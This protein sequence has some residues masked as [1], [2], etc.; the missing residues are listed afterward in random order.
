MVTSQTGMPEA[1][2]IV[3]LAT[4]FR[5]TGTDDNSLEFP[6]FIYALKDQKIINKAYF[7]FYWNPSQAFI[8]WG[9][10][11][12]SD[13][14]TDKTTGKLFKMH[15]LQSLPGDFWWTNYISGYRFVDTKG[16]TVDY[17]VGSTNNKIFTDSGTNCSY[18][19]SKYYNQFGNL[20][21]AYAGSYT[22][23]STDGYKIDCDKQSIMPDVFFNIGG[24]WY[25]QQ[26]IHY[27]YNN[28]QMQTKTCQICVK[29]AGNSDYWILG[30]KFLESYV[31]WHDSETMQW[32]LTPGLDSTKIQPVYG[33]VN[34]A[35]ENSWIAIV[36]TSIGVVGLL[37]VLIWS[38]IVRC[39]DSPAIKKGDEEDTFII[40]N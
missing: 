31:A 7:T 27:V 6:M 9:I 38:A 37:T 2:G 12:T 23:D 26:P 34:A 33:T 30:N 20:L 3:G 14:G 32:G 21:G 4:G 15:M 19:P 24:V 5:Y 1:A 29:D 36:T 28:D 39:N 17:A 40:L 16:N 13:F 8:N 35:A 18:V 22:Y 10:L 25:Q 11:D